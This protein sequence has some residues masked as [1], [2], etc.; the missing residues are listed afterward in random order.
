MDSELI[1]N[2]ASIVALSA[3]LVMASIGE[4]IT[5]R[6]G[7]VNLSLDGTILLSAMTGFV[8]AYTSNNVW[9]GVLAGVAVGAVVAL[10]VAASSIE[11]H[12]DQVAVGFVLTLLCDELSAFLG[13][14]YTRLPGPSVPYWPIPF[15]S[16]IPI[17]G[18]IFF[19]HNVLVYFSLFLIVFVWWWMYRTRP[20]LALRGIGERPAA[21][22]VRGANVN[23]LRY[24]YTLIGGGLV[25]MAGA[26]YSLSVKLGWSEGHV[27]GNGWIALAIV[28]FGGWHP[29]R[30]AFGAYLFAALRAL[31]SFMQQ[32]GASVVLVNATPW[33]LMILTLLL[34][35]SGAT[36]RLIA[37]S[38]PG[39]RRFLRGVLR[40]TPP[41]S[42]G[43]EFR[44]E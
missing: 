38:P 18:Q 8:A 43:V 2:L 17:I 26:T 42:L 25:G 34:V 15:L 35:G 27:R 24:L 19:T 29:F 10:I 31:S 21:A 44:R 4:T 30:V 41:E 12:Q 20:G 6:A 14:D 40:A 5:E 36:E 13:Q 28:I 22:F 23:R 33:I 9:V 16:D 37:I 11:L 1:R 32:L 39:A 3:P 7:V